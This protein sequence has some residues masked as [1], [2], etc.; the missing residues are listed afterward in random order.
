MIPAEF[1]L[2]IHRW[3]CAALRVSRILL[4]APRQ[5]RRLT[6]RSPFSHIT[7]VLMI[8][9]FLRGGR[10]FLSIIRNDLVMV[11]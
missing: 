9:S 2:S 8:D 7:P 11:G 5:I 10:C 6:S 3:R 4:H 1:V